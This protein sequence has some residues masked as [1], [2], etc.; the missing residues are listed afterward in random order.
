QFVQ[1]ELSRPPG[2]IEPL[3]Q[4]ITYEPFTYSAASMRAPFDAP[5]DIASTLQ[6]Q[7]TNDIMPD[8][9]RPREYLENFSIGSLTMVGSLARG[10]T[11]WALVE[12]ENGEVH[13]V[14]T[15]NYMGKNHGRVVATSSTRIDLVEIVPNGSGGWLERPQTITLQETP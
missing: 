4:F 15:G 2:Q 10:E 9:D 7:N 12:D 5:M 13:R 1:R 14:I 11:M 6:S 3:P 8:E